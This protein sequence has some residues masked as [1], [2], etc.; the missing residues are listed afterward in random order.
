MGILHPVKF[1]ASIPKKI[2]L[3]NGDSIEINEVQPGGGPSIQTEKVKETVKKEPI[4]SAYGYN[5]YTQEEISKFNKDVE[6]YKV[7]HPDNK[8]LSVWS[9][10][11]FKLVSWSWE[12]NS[13]L[14]SDYQKAV[15]AAAGSPG[16]SPLQYGQQFLGLY[17]LNKQVGMAADSAIKTVNDVLISGP[18][19]KAENELEKLVIIGMVLLVGGIAAVKLIEHE[20]D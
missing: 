18:V 16:F 2:T 19:K 7:E 8:D 13:Y 14:K 10:N 3:E 17:D 15:M 12:H 1:K 4:M 20:I 9:L 11:P 6:K 5:F